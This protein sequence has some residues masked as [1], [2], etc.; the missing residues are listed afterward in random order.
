[1]NRRITIKDIAQVVGVHHATV[2][3]ALRGESRITGETRSRIHA[4]AL[5][6]GYQPDP[7][8]RALCAYRQRSKPAAF[9]ETLGL[10]WVGQAAGDGER[11]SR[12]AQAAR[13]HAAA[14]G[15]RIDEL[16]VEPSAFN[17]IR[18]VLAA[19]GIRGMIIAGDGQGAA[20]GEAFD[21]TGF[22]A[23]DASTA[24]LFPQLHH[25]G[26]DQGAGI[27]MALGEL[28]QLGYRR[29]GLVLDARR[30]SPLHAAI[31]AGFLAAHPLGPVK[32]AALMRTVPM[33]T[34]R[35]VAGLTRQLR[36]DALMHADP[37]TESQLSALP[38]TAVPVVNLNLPA[39]MPSQ[40]GIAQRIESIAGGAV[41]MVV[42]QITHGRWGLPE[43]RRRV[44]LEGTWCDHAS[45]P[46]K[47]DERFMPA[48]SSGRAA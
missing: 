14:L 15:Y 7:M 8:M 6:L 20:C 4:A 16:D 2:S 3:R 40:A 5:E 9:Q 22:A 13:S 30:E 44:L 38:E 37:M 41:D 26:H 24:T 11:A 19:R 23:V 12:F 25:V 47:T 43:V 33:M 48:M 17:T 29:V 32:A 10:L 31:A 27:R 21:F 46:A 34:Q 36:L 35:A 18:R 45:C 42:D 1:M 39:A 28:G